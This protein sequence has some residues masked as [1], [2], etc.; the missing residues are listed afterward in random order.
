MRK[1]SLILLALALLGVPASAQE[2]VDR[3]ASAVDDHYNH[4]S[5]LVT[6]FTE[7]Y[8]GAGVSRQ[9]SGTLW[10]KRP[11]KMRWEYQQPRVKLFVSDGKTAYFYVPGERQVRRAEVKKLDDLRSPLRYLLGKTKLKKEFEGL[12]L[13]P[14]Q[15]PS[16]AGDLVL[17][18]VPRSLEQVDE[19]LLEITPENRIRRIVV[20]EVDGSVTEFSFADPQENVSLPDARFTFS[21]PP[22]V[23]TIETTDLAP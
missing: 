2:S 1:A 6:Q 7:S 21:P 4:L 5:S 19:V 10:L 9:E 8:R 14:D 3:I 20:R 16:T 12:S 17:R 22:G 18:G 23:E 13:A 15:K 11:G